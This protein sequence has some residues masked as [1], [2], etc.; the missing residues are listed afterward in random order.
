M[1]IVIHYAPVNTNALIIFDGLNFDCQ[2]E[3]VTI[4]PHHNFAL[5]NI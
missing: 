1:I 2:L 5:Y 4:P 3:T